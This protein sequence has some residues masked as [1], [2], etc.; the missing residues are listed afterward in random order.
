MENVFSKEFLDAQSERLLGHRERVINKLRASKEEI[1]TGGWP[2]AV[3]S[4][5]IANSHIGESI[6]MEL[7]EK[8]IHLLREI[9]EALGKI[10]EGTYGQCEETGEVINKRR[11]ER[12]PWTRLSLE[13]AQEQEESRPVL[14][15]AKAS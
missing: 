15:F 8:D 1:Q 13:A 7:H 4:G 10:E 12:V 3:E 5:D 9:D 14:P 2:G 6:S 11:L